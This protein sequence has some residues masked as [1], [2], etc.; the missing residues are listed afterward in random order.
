M[1]LLPVISIPRL[2]PEMMLLVLTAVPPIKLLGAEY[3]WIPVE[4]PRATCPVL[5]V[6][7]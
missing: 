2:L 7:I 3:N 6:P 4:F 5:S 1:A